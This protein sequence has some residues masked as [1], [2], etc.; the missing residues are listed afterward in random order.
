MRR[1]SSAGRLG[2]KPKSNA[3]SILQGRHATTFCAAS[4]GVALGFG[5]CLSTLA[6]KPCGRTRGHPGA[7]SIVRQAHHLPD[8]GNVT[9]WKS[10]QVSLQC[11]PQA[12]T[13]V[14]LMQAQAQR[15]CRAYGASPGN[16]VHGATCCSQSRRTGGG[17]RHIQTSPLQGFDGL[18]HRSFLGGTRTHQRPL[19]GLCWKQDSVPSD[20][21]NA[22]R[23]PVLEV[24]SRPP[25][26]LWSRKT[27][28]P[29]DRCHPCGSIAHSGP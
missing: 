21:R 26:T 17:H 16:A 2:T 22:A 14:L 28:R 27:W 3:P 6:A 15:W 11:T 1:G 5:P 19:F 23:S 20:P 9:S 12:D 13:C 4:S 29:G 18:L 8:S 7:F 10:G 25:I 24:K